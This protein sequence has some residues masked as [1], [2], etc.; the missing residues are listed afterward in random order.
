MLPGTFPSAQLSS[1]H[2]ESIDLTIDHI[3]GA[4]YCEKTQFC[5]G[6]SQHERGENYKIETVFL[7]DFIAN[8]S[9]TTLVLVNIKTNQIED[10]D[11]LELDLCCPQQPSIPRIRLG[12]REVPMQVR[13]LSP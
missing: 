9:W 6:L 11:P 10:S 12:R 4:E 1:S 2:M 3:A 8:Q 7:Q 13:L 5:A